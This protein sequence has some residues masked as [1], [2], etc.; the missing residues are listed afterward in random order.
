VANRAGS[1]YYPS[2]K[3]AEMLGMSGLALS[4][5]TSSFMVITSDGQKTNLGLSLK[6]E[7]K[8]LKVINYTR[9]DGRH[10][11]FS[12]K[13]VQLIRDYKVRFSGIPERL[14]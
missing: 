9:K 4:K 8:G 14:R 2:F 10:W 12:D 13:A 7:A 6:F 1:Q 3:A 5:I 11:E